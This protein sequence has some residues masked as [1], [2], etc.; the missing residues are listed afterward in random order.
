MSLLLK[1]S[2]YEFVFLRRAIQYSLFIIDVM[3]LLVKNCIHIAVAIN[4]VCHCE[5]VV[6]YCKGIRTRLE[7]KSLALHEAMKQ[8][9]DVRLSIS[10]LNGAVSRMMSL[11]VVYFLDRLITGNRLC[12]PLR[13]IFIS[14]VYPLKEFLHSYSTDRLNR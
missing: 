12:M 11:L 2:S 1:I 5:M 9:L 6:F 4:F 3:C 14:F 13:K 7:E 10:Q 8:I